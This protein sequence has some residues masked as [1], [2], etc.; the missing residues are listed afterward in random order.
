MSPWSFAA[1]TAD[2]PPPFA[3]RSWIG[4][5]LA[6]LVMTTILSSSPSVAADGER[7]PAASPSLSPG[8]LLAEKYCTTCH[9]LPEPEMLTKMAWIH[10]IQPEMAKWLGLER[11]DYEG[12]PDGR[13]LEEAKLY[14]NSPLISEADWFVL[15]DYYRAAA[16]SSPLP[17]PAKPAPGPPL[18]SFR[19]HPL[20]PVPGV[21]MISMLQIDPAA[22][23]LHVADGFNGGFWS[24]DQTG[25]ILHKHRFASPAVRWI[26]GQRRSYLTLIGRLFPSDA[27]EGVVLALP[28]DF[29]RGSPRPILENLRRPTDIVARDLNEDGREDFAVC[30][31]GNR[32]GRFSW[33][34]N[35]GDGRFDETILLDR[36]GALAVQSLDLTRD[37][38][39][40]LIV[41][42]GQAREGVYLFINQGR[43]AFQ[44]Q[45]LLEKPPTWGFAAM[46]LVD[47]NKDGAV[48]LITANGD[49]GDLA[50]PLKSYH[51]VRL[52]LNDGQNHFREVY[53]YPLHGAYKVV[54]R[55]FDG[56]GDLDIAAVAYYADFSQDAPETFVY[57]ENQGQMKFIP[58]F[59][60]EASLGRWMT[61]EAGDLD[62]DGDDDLVLGS[63][64]KGPTTTPVPASLRD[65]WRKSG[66][67]V[68]FLENLRR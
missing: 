59:L 7:P 54:A 52:Y 24:L 3:F 58:R 41:L 38:R 55:D 19:P 2:S 31:F 10:Q 60:P 8:R 11:V 62:G 20:N 39:P 17:Q 53:F 45:P 61:M 13:V 64:L 42:T 34:A 6:G 9:L 49:N 35:Q 15:W 67:A 1:P 18:A 14:P 40:D 50:L 47:F 30:Q 25:S 63:F 16:P 51:G 44:L 21:P 33:F 46:E 23:R 22:K 26:F 29:E 66:A 57:L 5:S 65:R 28:E 4:W 37:G 12:L 27:T 32:L 36:P 48:D 56:D 43:G 68:L